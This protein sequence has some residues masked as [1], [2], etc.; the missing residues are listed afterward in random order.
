MKKIISVVLLSIFLLSAS[1]INDGGWEKLLD[2]DLSKWRIYQS[3]RHKDD[4]HGKA[5]VNEKGELIQPIGYDKN[6]AGLVSVTMVNNEPVVRISGETYGCMFTKQEFQNYHLK[7]M[8]KFGDKK[9][10]PR[11]NEP[12]D[13]GL[14]YHSQGEL[15]VDYWRSWMQ[16]EEF[17]IMEGGFGDYWCVAAVGAHIKMHDPAAR[18]DM[19]VYDPKGIDTQMGVGGHR[20]G[21][22]QH[23]HDYEKPGDWN[24]VEL[25]C[26]GDKS[27][28]IIN[29]HVV[30]ALTQ[31]V[32]KDGDIIKPLVKGKIQLQSE[33]AEVFYK[34]VQIKSINGI[35]SEY[36]SYFE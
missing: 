12:K 21:F 25:I 29:G 26:Y 33:A 10:T 31:L 11:L 20:S 34:D 7:L 35:P 5:P 16:A 32:Y 30:M 14:L 22:V 9:W 17:Q 13:S 23:S 6:E 3:F 15:G 36:A 27:L 24:S 18:K 1:F 19:A 4:Y 8:V 2:K 28:Q